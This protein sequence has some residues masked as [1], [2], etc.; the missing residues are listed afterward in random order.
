MKSSHLANISDTVLLSNIKT[1]VNKERELAA[2]IIDHLAEI[3]KRK[4]Y[5]EL[6]YRSL[7]EYCVKELFLSEDQAGRKITAMRVS[8]RV[9][10]IKNKIDNGELS[11]SNANLLSSF[12]NQAKTSPMEK[13]DVVNRVAGTSKRECENILNSIKNEKG[14]SNSPKAPHIRN[15]TSDTVRLSLSIS[16]KTMAKIKRLKG[17]YAHKQDM[18]LTK[19][20]DL[21]ADALLEQEEAKQIPKQ[22]QESIKTPIKKGRYIPKNIRTQVFKRAKNKCELCGSIH[23]LQMDHRK[24]FAFGG[25]NS[26]SNLRL[27]CRNCNIRAGIKIFGTN[28]MKRSNLHALERVKLHDL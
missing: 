10:A 24:P 14:L 22:K 2:R 8:L 12:F 28:K 17:I 16:K 18:D 19:I 13:K 15:E 1:L 27:I 11:I 3:E 26:I 7:F 23:A 21:M 6:K 20:I 9:P 5:S 25:D 4:L